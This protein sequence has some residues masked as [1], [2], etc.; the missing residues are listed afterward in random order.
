MQL[1]RSPVQCCLGDLEAEAAPKLMVGI[2]S[3]NVNNYEL[4]GILPTSGAI[5]IGDGAYPSPQLELLQRF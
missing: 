3:G 2:T 1:Y 5:G 4:P